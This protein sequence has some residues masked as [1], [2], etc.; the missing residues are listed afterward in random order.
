MRAAHNL[1][2]DHRVREQELPV[3]AL[4]LVQEA[5]Q[6]DHVADAEPARR[7]HRHDLVLRLRLV[8]QAPQQRHDADRPREHSIDE[9]CHRLQRRPRD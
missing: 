8:Q 7:Q 1:L 2:A 3:A 5:H 6:A 9:R 4:V